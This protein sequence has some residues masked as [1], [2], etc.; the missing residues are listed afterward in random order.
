LPGEQDEWAGGKLLIFVEPTFLFFVQDILRLGVEDQV[1]GGRFGG[2]CG[3]EER[4]GIDID[5]YGDRRLLSL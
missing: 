1:I 3:D 2:G 4:G 5:L